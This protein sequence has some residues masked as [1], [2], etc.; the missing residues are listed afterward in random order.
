ME[1]LELALELPLGKTQGIVL[2]SEVI[3]VLVGLSK[4]SLSLATAAVGLLKKSAGLFQLAVKGIGTA[5]SNAV[6]L[7]VFGGKALLL[8]NAGLHVLDLTLELLDVL[9][10][11][12]VGLV[13]V[14]KSDLE[15]VDVGLE[16]LLHAKS[17]SLALSF[18]LKGSLHGIDGALV[19]LAKVR[20]NI[21]KCYSYRQ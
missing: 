12:R 4:L 14:V 2:G 19:A 9:L 5:F 11:V 3:E 17:L 13:G 21:E 20:E 10:E 8:L 18:S 15:L 7:A 16:L 1:S 6:L